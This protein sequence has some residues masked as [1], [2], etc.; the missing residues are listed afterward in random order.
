[1]DLKGQPSFSTR[2]YRGEENDG[3]IPALA[4]STGALTLVLTGDG[5]PQFVDDVRR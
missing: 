2:N 1:M 5:N 3:V 4:V